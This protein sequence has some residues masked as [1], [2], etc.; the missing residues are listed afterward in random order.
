MKHRYRGFRSINGGTPQSSTLIGISLINHPGIGVL[1]FQNPY[2][3]FHPGWFIG[4]PR[5]IILLFTRFSRYEWIIFSQVFRKKN[6]KTLKNMKVEKKKKNKIPKVSRNS[7]RTRPSQ[8]SLQPSDSRRL[9][10]ELARPRE[11]PGFPLERKGVSLM[12][13]IKES[14]WYFWWLKKKHTPKNPKRVFHK[15]HREMCFDSLPGS[16]FIVFV[17]CVFFGG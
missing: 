13:K 12:G 1:P 11:T 5:S 8:A 3:P 7:L 6:K 16:L 10:S 15:T 4:I 14:R 9:R 17:C 2:I